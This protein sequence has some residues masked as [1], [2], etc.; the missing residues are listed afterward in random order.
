MS[1]NMKKG[2]SDDLRQIGVVTKYELLKHVRSKRMI[3]FV[4]IAALMFILVTVLSLAI[5]GSL[6]DDKTEFMETYVG[7]VDLML[8]IG[9]SLFCASTIAAEFEER[10]ALLMFPRPIKKTSFFMGK[11]LAC[12]IICGGVMLI[13]YTICIITSIINT[14][15]LDL[16]VFGSIGMA[17]M[18][19]LGAGGFALLMSSIFKRGAIAVIVTIASLL[20]ILQVVSALLET[21]DIEPMFSI[22]YAGKDILNFL[23]GNVTT[24]FSFKI[25]DEWTFTYKVFYPSHLKAFSIM[26]IWA[27]VTTTLSAL[28]FRRKEF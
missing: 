19:M 15:G 3:V 12:Y 13:Y 24:G 28:I 18:F 8:I 7:M 5:N 1:E 6:P 2:I 17:M 16:N 25:S 11:V 9:V 22:T 10:T 23:S 4:A 14:G 20:L 27:T 26:A 21:F